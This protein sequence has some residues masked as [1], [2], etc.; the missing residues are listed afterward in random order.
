VLELGEQKKKMNRE[1][2]IMETTRTT[3]DVVQQKLA[4]FEQVESE[5]EACFRFVQEVHGL[6]CFAEF[7]IAE[8]VRYLHALWICECKDRLLSIYKNIERYEGRYCLELLKSWQEIGTN[9]DVVAFLQRKL[10]TLPFVD[11][12][13]QLHEAELHNGDFG[14][15]QR[16]RHGRHILL[17]RGMN[18]LHAFDAMFALSEEQLVQEVRDA[19]NCYGHNPLQIEQQLEAMDSAIYSYMPHQE[20]AQRSMKLMNKLG[21]Q[22]TS[23]PVDQ[24]GQRSWRVLEPTEPLSPYAEHVIPGYQELTLPQHNNIKDEP[25]IDHLERSD[26]GTM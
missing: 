2:M 10:D 9:A 8:S 13:R 12:T 20:L 23:K 5:F 4:A 18:L 22:V 26:S 17:N 15:A 19:C 24:P 3:Q 7:P 11:L 25:F 1:E 21:V 14:L 6:K 16:L